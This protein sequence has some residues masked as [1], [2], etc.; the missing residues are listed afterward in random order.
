VIKVRYVDCACV[1]VGRSA[2]VICLDHPH[3][4]NGTWVTT[5]L[6]RAIQQ[7]PAGPL[8]TTLNT[9]YIPEDPM[10][11]SDNAG[12]WTPELVRE[13]SRTLK[14]RVKEAQNATG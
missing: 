9:L 5:T 7:S 6:V 4:P 10:L 1:E 8:F 12:Y 2:R 3:V 13:F 14:R 11:F